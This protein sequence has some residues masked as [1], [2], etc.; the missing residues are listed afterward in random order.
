VIGR[1]EDVERPQPV[2]ASRRIPGLAH[3][4]SGPG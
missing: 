2:P 3:V 1:V 4:K